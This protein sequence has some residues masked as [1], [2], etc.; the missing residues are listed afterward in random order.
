MQLKALIKV[1]KCAAG[2]N[3]KCD[4]RKEAKRQW[5]KSSIIDMRPHLSKD[6]H[7]AAARVYAQNL[8][9]R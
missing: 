5:G 6:D 7:N 3:A 2:E 9:M 1:R 4:A 8:L